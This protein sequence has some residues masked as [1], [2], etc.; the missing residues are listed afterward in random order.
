MGASL[1]DPQTEHIGEKQ[2]YVKLNKT[3]PLVI[4][5]KP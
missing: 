1:S 4:L 2:A 5:D 3:L